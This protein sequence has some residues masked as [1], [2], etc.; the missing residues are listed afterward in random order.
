MRQKILVTRPIFPDVIERL[1]EYFDV[2]V[3]E[4]EKYAPAQLKAAL[5]G[6]RGVLLAGGRR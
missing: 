6:K 4:G 2:E 5:G 1:R 3:N